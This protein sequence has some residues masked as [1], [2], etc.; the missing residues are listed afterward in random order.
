MAQF[1]PFRR[2][3]GEQQ[4]AL[5]CSALSKTVSSAVSPPEISQR[6]HLQRETF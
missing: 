1:V 5:G 4:P 3:L 2:T 6:S